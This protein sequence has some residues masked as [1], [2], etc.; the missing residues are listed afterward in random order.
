MSILST[1]KIISSH[2]LN[3]K[4]KFKS[5]LRFIGWQINTKLNPYPIIYSFTEK[6]KL[7]IKKGMTGATGNLYCGLHEYEDMS[8][9]LHFLRREDFFVDIG[10]NV[11]SYTVLASGH[12]GAKTISIEPVPSTFGYLMDNI[13]INRITDRVTA[14]NAAIGSEK[15]FVNFTKSLDAMNHVACENENDDIIKVPVEVLDD[16]LS[17]RETP[18]LIKIDVEGFET[19]VV[20]GACSTLKK[21]GLKAIIIEL[22]G[23]GARY[24]YDE[25]DIHDTLM[26]LGFKPFLYNPV[27]RELTLADS[28]GA[29]NTI[30][31]RD[32]SYV[33]DRVKNAPEVRI[34]NSKI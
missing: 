27:K 9:L 26:N 16:I 34:K 1:L 32:V 25:K 30:Y 18:A 21:D 5:I 7:I 4:N 10:A 31:I 17:G 3:K 6:S 13:N 29:F 33:E 15:G 23:M 11:G 28:Y 12:A 22:N 14:L 24:G 20:K 2:P 8:F 19:N